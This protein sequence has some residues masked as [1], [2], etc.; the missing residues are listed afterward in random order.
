MRN[1]KL[2]WQ[3]ENLDISSNKVKKKKNRDHTPPLELKS[4]LKTAATKKTRIVWA[5]LQVI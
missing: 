4:Y 1:S 3:F 2:L 5:F